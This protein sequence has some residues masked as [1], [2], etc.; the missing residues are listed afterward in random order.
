L[1]TGYS[2]NNPITGGCGC[3]YFLITATATNCTPII[4]VLATCC[5]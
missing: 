2:V 5:C 3:D 4:S 1:K